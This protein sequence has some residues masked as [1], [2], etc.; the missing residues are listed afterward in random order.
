MLVVGVLAGCAP[1][2]SDAGG[3]DPSAPERAMYFACAAVTDAQRALTDASAAELERLGLTTADPQAL[4][5]TLV[6]GSVAAPDYWAALRGAATDDAPAA[7]E[8]DL[9]T[10]DDFWQGLAE[11]LSAIT[12]P[13]AE[14]AT[15]SAA[16]Q[17]LSALSAT[18]PDERVPPA[19]Q[20]VEEAVEL[21]CS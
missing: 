9:A 7:L 4:T 15:V 14:P 11:E 17:Q 5:V 19:Q 21:S 3:P 18:A 13:D 8:T 10:L 12:I 6:A 20:R 16:G 2:D 1:D